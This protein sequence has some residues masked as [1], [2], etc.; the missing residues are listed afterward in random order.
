M[1]M[2][3]LWSQIPCSSKAISVFSCRPIFDDASGGS[4]L[5]SN[6][7]ML[8]WEGTHIRL[9]AVAAVFVL[10]YLVCMPISVAYVLLR[11]GS[12]GVR[13]TSPVYKV[14]LFLCKSHFIEQKDP[15]FTRS[16]SLK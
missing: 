5:A 15:F 14:L 9:C 13:S 11:S 8:C 6:P 12:N 1:I 2:S 10:F 4:Y 7:S 3:S 16:H